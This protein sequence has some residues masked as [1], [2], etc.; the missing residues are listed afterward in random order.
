MESSN[1]SSGATRGAVWRRRRELRRRRGLRRQRRRRDRRGRRSRRIH[2]RANPRYQRRRSRRQSAA[3]HE[4]AHAGQFI[5][6]RLHHRVGIVVADDG[7][8]VDLDHQRFEFMAEIAHGADARHSR[9]ALESMQLPLQLRDPLLVPAIAIPGSEGY[10]RRIQ[11][12]GRLFAID[13]R[14]FVI[15]IL[16][17]R[18]HLARFGRFGCFEHL[19]HPECFER[20]EHLGRLGCLRR[21]GRFE[22]LGHLECFERLEH[23]G[24]LERLLRCGHFER[25]GHLGR[26][27]GLGR[28]RCN[29]LDHRRRAGVDGIAG[30]R[31]VEFAFDVLQTREQSRLF[32]EERRRF[33]DMRY[34]VVDGA[35]RV[36][37]GGESRVGQ[38][39]AAVENLAHDVIQR[40]GDPYAMPRLRHLRA[41]AQGM[42][43]AKH[44]LRQLVRGRLARTLAQVFA[45]LGQMARRLLAV[46][47]MQQG[48]HDGRRVGGFGRRLRDRLD[49]HRRRGR[50]RHSG[51]GHGRR[52][53][54]FG[55]H[56]HGALIRF[57]AVGVGEGA[58]HQRFDRRR[59]AT[60]RFQLFHQRRQHGNG[61]AQQ[62]HHSG[63]ARQSLVDDPIQQILDRPAKLCDRAGAHH[64]A[65]AFQGVETAPHQGEGFQIHGILVP[66]R[67]A[68]L[69][70]SD[71]F[72]GF[73]DEE[74]DE[75][76]VHRFGLGQ[77]DQGIR[78]HISR[79]AAFHG[80]RRDRIELDGLGGVVAGDGD[81]RDPRRRFVLE[82]LDAHLGVVEHVPGI[83]AA[84]LQSLHVILD[85]DDRVGHPFQADGVRRG[86]AR[87]DELAHL[88]A[89]RIHQFHRSALAQHQ[90][91]GGDAAQ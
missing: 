38:S 73:L 52:S 39:M 89:D 26:L 42:D 79:R 43:G 11:Q 6:A 68:V 8:A 37:Q 14:D 12:F 25:F 18:G 86:C 51:D 3:A 85:A 33:V 9:S 72:L 87:L 48:I 17:R 5:Q 91:A 83:V 31:G 40:L 21:C 19:G 74:L 75:L 78:R 69:D 28:H 32:R 49:G 90:Q 77:R 4:V 58:R 81:I 23:L 50:G 84:A 1:S 7:A 62:G 46:N 80:N 27:W 63:R 13:I 53:A 47:V 29:G 71:F 16:S 20:L 61:A 36:A 56:R 22:R 44:R 30:D 54:I 45:N 67:E 10:L 57:A 76:R 88:R 2:Q 24:R 35:N 15:E 34:H 82:R 66:L 70:R 64:A 41:A 59:A 55:R 60:P 65:T